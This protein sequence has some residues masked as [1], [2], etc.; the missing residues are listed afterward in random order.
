MVTY[1]PEKETIKE[2]IKLQKIEKDILNHLHSLLRSST[3]N[4]EIYVHSFVHDRYLNI[5]LIYENRGIF[6][7]TEKVLDGKEIFNFKNYLNSY[8]KLKYTK[9][10]FVSEDYFH[11]TN[12]E[13]TNNEIYIEFQSYKKKLDSLYS[14]K[15]VIHEEIVQEFKG[16]LFRRYN[17]VENDIVFDF[18]KKQE[19]LILREKDFKVKGAAGTGKTMVMLTKAVRHYRE[20]G[21]KNLIV[22]FNITARN[23]LREKLN[24]MYKDIDNSYFTIV[25]YHGLRNPNKQ[26]NNIFIDEAQDFEKAWYSNIKEYM[27][28]DGKRYLF[29]DEKQNIYCRDLDKK[30]MS[31]PIPGGWHK[32]KNSYRMEG[33]TVDLALNFQKIFY[34]NKYEIDEIEKKEVNMISLNFGEHQ[35]IGELEYKYF[36]YSSGFRKN[37]VVEYIH[38]IIDEKKL[39]HSK[40]AVLT[41]EVKTILTI[42]KS[43]EN[44]LDLNGVSSE[45]L[46]EYENIMNS[47]LSSNKDAANKSL[48]AIRRNR[49][50]NFKSFGDFL[51]FSTIH[52]FKG[53]ERDNIILVIS[54]AGKKMAS[55]MDEVV[56]TGITRAKKNLYII[57][58]GLEKYNEF[59]KNNI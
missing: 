5:V 45:T 32:L 59:F 3:E 51:I 21:H 17:E 4:I 46:D 1:I 39:E 15:S 58:V 37:D 31:T 13:K 53:L 12:L 52:S 33:A 28:D 8:L 49:K 2:K 25:H 19:E 11:F 43:F 55:K 16:L 23:I 6:V 38:S 27:I 41:A 47:E 7:I 24:R 48:E 50:L 26:Y 56:Y 14:T 54:D 22:V 34:S 29:G 44:S 9:K 35:K 30:D 40:T 36:D 42:M 10:H 20:F 57:N 18:N